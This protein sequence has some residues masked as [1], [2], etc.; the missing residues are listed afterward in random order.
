MAQMKPLLQSSEQLLSRRQLQARW[1]CCIETIKRKQYAGL[2]KPIFLSARMI[3]YSVQNVEEI[4]AA[5]AGGW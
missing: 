2:L 4:E 5:A 1:G 3:R